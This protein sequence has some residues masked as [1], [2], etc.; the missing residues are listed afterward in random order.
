LVHAEKKSPRK[1][2]KFR[3]IKTK[4]AIVQK[5]WVMGKF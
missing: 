3:K 4:N 5:L 2:L 1:K